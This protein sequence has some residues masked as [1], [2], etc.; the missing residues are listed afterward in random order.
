MCVTTI[1]RRCRDHLKEKEWV[2][3]KQRNSCHKIYLKGQ[4]LQ[5]VLSMNEIYNGVVKSS[6]GEVY[7]SR[8]ETVKIW[9]T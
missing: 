1:L 9:D 7:T 5:I 4:L 6:D 2:S 8:A 3:K